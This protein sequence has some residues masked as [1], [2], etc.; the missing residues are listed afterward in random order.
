M[1]I[2]ACY[3]PMPLSACMLHFDTYTFWHYVFTVFLLWVATCI[4][5]LTESHTAKINTVY[6]GI[7][8]EPVPITVTLANVTQKSWHS[9]MYTAIDHYTSK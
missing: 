4:N 7:F 1:I 5:L 9:T 6:I 2:V 3:H 8:M